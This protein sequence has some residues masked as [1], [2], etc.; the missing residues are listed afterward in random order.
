MV[1]AFQKFKKEANARMD[2]A[3]QH[4]KDEFK[5]M[6]TGRANTAMVEDIRFDFYGNVSPIKSASSLS[7]PDPHTIVIDPWD[8]GV[9]KAIEKGISESG[10]SLSAVN[11]GK[12]IRVGIP[13][14]TEQTK[15]EYVKHI[16]ELAEE[17]KVGIRNERREINNQVKKLSKDGHIGEDDERKELDEIQKVTDTHMKNI[18]ELVIKKEKEM[19]E[20]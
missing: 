10:L 19:M 8:K 5:K 17:I 9:L 15:K 6:R 2:K 14:M 20:V 11:D 13:P 4:L 3:I 12:V 7:T 16:K 18:D 1:E